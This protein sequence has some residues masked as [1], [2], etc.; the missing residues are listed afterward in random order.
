MILFIVKIIERCK[1]HLSVSLIKE[2]AT[3]FD[4]RFSFGQITYEDNHK[5]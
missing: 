3:Q 1:A 4:N 5:E 2:H